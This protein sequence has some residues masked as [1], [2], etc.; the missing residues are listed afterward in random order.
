MLVYEPVDDVRSPKSLWAPRSMQLKR[1]DRAVADL[2]EIADLL[3]AHTGIRYEF[4]APPRLFRSN[5][6]TA[7]WTNLYSV[8]HQANPR[9]QMTKAKAEPRGPISAT[10]LIAGNYAQQR[11][12]T[13]RGPI[14]APQPEG[15]RHS[16][17]ELA[18]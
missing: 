3:A 9:T 11:S 10:C 17:L 6:R 13:A 15:P 8:T 4:A 14:R 12:R 5:H 18:S 16:N 7:E 2:S 1:P